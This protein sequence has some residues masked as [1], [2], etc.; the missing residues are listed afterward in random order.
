VVAEPVPR[1]A[2]VVVIGGGI[3]GS[4]T[5]YF[6][7]KRGAQVALLEKG[8]LSDEQSGRN[9]GWIRQ[10]GRNPREL[11]LAMLSL[12]TWADLARD[13][14][15]DTE[16]AQAGSLRLAY[17]E[18][19][20]A[21]YQRWTQMARD[22]GLDTHVLSARKV[23]KLIP[24]LEGPYLGGAYTPSDAQMEP[25]KAT[26]AV[27][28]AAQKF[29]AKIHTHC[30]V[31]GLEVAGGAL[32]QVLT[33]HGPIKTPVVV[34]AAGAWSSKVGRMVGLDLPQRAVRATVARTSVVKPVTRTLVWAEGVAIRQ[35]RDGSI[36]IAEGGG[37]LDITLATFR[38]LWAF[39]P[40]Y[41]RNRRHL[42]LHVGMELWRDIGRALPWSS[43][44]KHP[45]A[46]AVGHEPPPNLSVVQRTRER[47]L[48]LIPTLGDVSI[49][50]AWAGIIDA[51]PD[52]VPV[53]GE[54]PEVKGF[55]FTTG[56]S[57]HG[58]AL[59]PGAGRVISEFVLDGKA[60]I[61]LRPLRYARFREKDPA[62]WT[63]TI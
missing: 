15:L 60:S 13:L 12:N 36:N 39:L 37:D 56:F 10:Q 27:A 19:T 11:P 29:G 28:R 59:G 21:K 58:F 55:L 51:T 4:A 38:H 5:A 14:D 2:D 41:W 25:R 62:D 61:D 20:M 57:G 17:T 53:L 48:K 43:T 18:E 23:K 22:L 63:Q 30:A 3:V 34:C 42:R 52:G 46:Q 6:L 50:L 54:V 9:W 1:Q 24:A 49:Q 35:R 31:E 8:E 40:N 33:E 44:K 16:W 32:R 7:A 26:T 45:F 47:L